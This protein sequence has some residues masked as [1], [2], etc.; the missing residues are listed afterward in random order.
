LRVPFANEKRAG[1][2]I[3][4]VRPP[5]SVRSEHKEG[6]STRRRIR[7]RARLTGRGRR[8]RRRIPHETRR[9]GIHLRIRGALRFP[10]GSRCENRL[11]RSWENSAGRGPRRARQGQSDG[12]SVRQIKW[13]IAPPKP[14][15]RNPSR[16]ADTQAF[17]LSA[18]RMRTNSTR[19]AAGKTV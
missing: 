17:A 18:W 7:F 8:A 6:K 5:S 10:H 4:L 9:S 16:T 19:V 3:A 2:P 15:N 14:A 12:S 13:E 1:L 11:P